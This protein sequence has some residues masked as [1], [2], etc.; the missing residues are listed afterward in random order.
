MWAAIRSIRDGLSATEGLRQFRDAGGAI[1]TDTWYKLRAEAGAAIAARGSE[2]AANLDAIPSGNEVTL[3]STTNARGVLQQ[4][5]V[6]Y[7]IKGTDVIA[8]R[9]FSVTGVDFVSR[10]AAI[11]TALQTMAQAQAEDKYADQVILGAAYVGSYRMTP[12]GME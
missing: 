6:T 10:Q 5:E 1:R 3:F 2:L 7:R 4:V 9:P 11:E 12:G 8:T